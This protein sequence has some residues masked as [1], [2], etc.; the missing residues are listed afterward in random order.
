MRKLTIATMCLV[1]LLAAACGS[2]DQS[3][4]GTAGAGGQSAGAGGGTIVSAIGSDLANL[5]PHLTTV[6]ATN[7]FNAYNYDTLVTFTP[8]GRLVSNL[9]EKWEGDA[10]SVTYTLRDNV[11]CS[12]GTTLTAGDVAK[13]YEFIKD[14]QTTMIPQ[15]IPSTDFTVTSDDASRTVTIELT[16]PFGFLVPSAGAIPIVCANGLADRSLLAKGSAGTGPYQ[17]VEVVGNDHYTIKRRNDYAWG[18]DG[19]KTPD[20]APDKITFKVVPDETTAASLLLAGEVQL[21]A[22][23]GPDKERIQAQNMFSRETIGIGGELWF[24]HRKGH[25]AADV[26]YRRILTQAL[27]LDRVRGAALMKAPTGMIAS[28][29]TFCPGDTLSNALPAFDLEGSK[30]ALDAAGWKPGADGIREKDG[31]KLTIPFFYAT[32]SPQRIAAAELISTMWRDVGIEVTGKA[33]PNTQLLQTMAQDDS[34]EVAWVNLNAGLPTQ[35]VGFLSGPTPP[36]GSNF[37][38]VDNTEYST[39]AAK[40]SVTA[41]D[42][43]CALWNDAE[44]AIFAEVNVVPWGLNTSP[45]F[46][47]GVEF[48]LSFGSVVPTSLRRTK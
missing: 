16:E 3:N 25:L 14:N 7:A 46:G 13:N 31:K 12:D 41:G 18:P 29:P 1:G 37:A 4:Q 45:V 26:E 22:V 8:D 27:D 28:Q 17:V 30:S 20:A 34:W 21:A 47:N 9:A 43:G 15:F 40:A 11:T 33:L 36:T 42:A 5:D 44:K 39:L 19:A 6:A 48:E 32:G 38:A 2:T 10:T 35:N 24:N 23:A